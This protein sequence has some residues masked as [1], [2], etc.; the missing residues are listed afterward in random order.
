MSISELANDE[1]LRTNRHNLNLKAVI[2][3]HL[4]PVVARLGLNAGAAAELS[5]AVQ[6][7]AAASPVQKTSSATALDGLVKYI[8][9]ESITL[10]LAA[11]AAFSS[12]KKPAPTLGPMYLYWGF[13][14][15]TPILF[16]LIYLGKRRSQ[17]LPLLPDTIG[18]WP[19]W[20]LIASTIAFM[21]WALA[22]PPL[23]DGDLGKITVAFGALLVS[24]LLSL[25][26]SVVEPDP[27]PAPVP[28]PAPAP[29]PT[30]TPTPTPTPAPTP[31]PKTG[32]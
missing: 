32:P 5:A 8:P 16:L 20:K 29:V 21:V 13:V 23:V 30:P 9:T 19:W 17:N 25:I 28:V 1:I 24:T 6:P 14:V 10:Y 15:L 27:V 12:L 3:H 4:D 26:G 2:D 18:G 7:I 31:A 11:T 22:V